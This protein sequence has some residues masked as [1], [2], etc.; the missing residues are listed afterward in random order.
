[1]LEALDG[2]GGLGIYA[3]FWAGLEDLKVLGQ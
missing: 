1:M 3:D 2:F